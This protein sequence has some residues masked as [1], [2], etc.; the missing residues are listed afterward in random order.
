MPEAGEQTAFII[1]VH[2]ICQRIECTGK[3]LLI[4]TQ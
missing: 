1:Q 4:L 2:R 3:S